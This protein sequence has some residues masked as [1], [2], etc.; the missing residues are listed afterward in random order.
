MVGFISNYFETSVQ[1]FQ[2]NHPPHLMRKCHPGK[3][4]PEISPL[5]DRFA[6]SQTA[7]DHEGD[8]AD[9]VHSQLLKPIRQAF[10]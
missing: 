9:S 8:A 2:Q 6:Q 10:G 3:G 1:L 7:A 5:A 4:K